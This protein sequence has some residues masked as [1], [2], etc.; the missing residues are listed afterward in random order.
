MSVKP[1]VDPMCFN[2][3]EYFVGNDAAEARKWAL[4]AEIQHTVED[5]LLYRDPP[6]EAA[7]PEQNRKRRA[8]RPRKVRGAD[9]AE[10]PAREAGTDHPAGWRFR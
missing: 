6:D 8:E 5:W 10:S 9:P 1:L 4:A 7:K 2:L 3:A